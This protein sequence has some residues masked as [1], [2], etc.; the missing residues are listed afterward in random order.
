VDD[1]E[2]H[3]PYLQA[4]AHRMLGPTGDADDAVQE[5]WLRLARADGDEV[6]NARAWLTTVLARVCMDI[7]RARAGRRRR[8]VGLDEA[9]AVAAS[10]PEQE[11]VL[12]DSVGVALL[13]VLDVLSPAER[14]AFVLHDTF[15]VPFEQIATILGR[16]VPATKM[17]ASR[18]RHRIRAAPSETS[19]PG[20]PARWRVVE[21][22]LAASRRGDFTAL[23]D[24][25]DPV[26]TA[27]ADAAASASGRAVWLTGAQ[28]VASQALA[29]ATRAAYARVGLF[30]GEPAILLKPHG[31][32][33]LALTFTIA[34]HRIVEVDI[35]AD[36]QRLRQRADSGWTEPL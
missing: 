12:A 20:L 7:L 1:F 26:V 33:A 29:F 15:A 16:S 17:L 11:A 9:P 3:R 21:A 18:A 13:V 34:G 2:T 32:L 22:F 10:G 31:R 36:P 28:T 27:R 8:E 6:R 24:I 30:D 4:M 25:L 19:D 35:I 14:L 23:L 5:T